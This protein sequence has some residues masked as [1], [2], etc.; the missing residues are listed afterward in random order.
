MTLRN[1]T[2]VL[3][4]AAIWS[5]IA[6]MRQQGRISQS[7]LI[8]VPATLPLEAF[9]DRLLAQILCLD[10][11]MVPC[12]SCKMCTK[13]LQSIHPD[14]HEIRPENAAG[15]IKIEQIR[16]MQTIAYQTPQ[17]GDRQ[18][19]LIHPAEAMNQAAASALLKILEEPTASTMF[20]LVTTNPSLL[21]PTIVSRCQQIQIEQGFL[22]DDPLM[23]S[24]TYAE[25]TPRGIL[26]AQRFEL[27]AGIDALLAQQMSP[28]GLAEQWANYPL[29][30]M[31]WFFATLL[32]KLI[33]RTLL[34]NDVLDDA[35]QVCAFFSK[36]W[37]PEFLF[38]QLDEIY[39]IFGQLQQNI[40]L[41]ATMVW[42]RILLNFLEGSVYAH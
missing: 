2:P 1:L 9:L 7:L 32:T 26:F 5:Q 40:N 36:S 13:V 42:E 35:Y 41:N 8:V 28:S 4:S 34:Q 29:Q 17:L 22:N 6:R 3:P 37:R 20:I 33:Q 15:S 12:G 10:M 19:V 30:D 38:Y 31:L 16:E 18:I 25:S 23:L 27:F 39:S 21:L 24:Q 11:A 14:V